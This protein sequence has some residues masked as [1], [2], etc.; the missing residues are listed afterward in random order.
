MGASP[1]AAAAA[2]PD[3]YAG[4]VLTGVPLIRP[5][6]SKK[7]PLKLRVARRA[8]ALR[9]LGAGPVDRL[10]ERMG[11]DDY[12]A[13][14]GTMRGVLVRTVNESYQDEL[15][16]LRCPVRLVWGADDAVAPVR[17]AEA[18]LALLHDGTLEVFDGVGHDL[19]LLEADRLRVI[20]EGF[21]A[22]PAM[23]LSP[24]SR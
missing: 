2:R 20:V 23:G 18:A 16:A 1:C 24:E 3:L 17:V 4:L 5:A 6:S 21:P 11:S 22:S 10:R 14:H 13:A 7:P 9:L 19:P 8:H 12:R 15:A